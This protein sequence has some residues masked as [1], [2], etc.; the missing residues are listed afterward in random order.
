MT[1][2]RTPANAPHVKKAVRMRAR[3]KRD[4]SAILNLENWRRP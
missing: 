3:Y 2:P 1:F 4:P